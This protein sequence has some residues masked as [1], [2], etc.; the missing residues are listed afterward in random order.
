MMG[1]DVRIWKF[2]LPIDTDRF[3]IDM[4]GYMKSLAVQ[5]QEG[6]PCL[7]AAVIVNEPV[8]PVELCWVG[9]GHNLPDD[10]RDYIGTVQLPGTALVLHLW[11]T[12][13]VL[14]HGVQTESIGEQ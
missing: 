10:V 12:N 2:P 11:D 3:T 13:T 9:T 7:W 14:W 8:A 4:P 5:L 1:E 6:S